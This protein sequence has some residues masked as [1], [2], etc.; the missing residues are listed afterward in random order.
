MQQ[1]DKNGAKVLIKTLSQKS[2]SIS[3]SNNKSDTIDN[4][5]LVVHNQTVKFLIEFSAGALGGVISR[6]A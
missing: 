5:S 6:T 2:S 1:V 4:Q 3:K